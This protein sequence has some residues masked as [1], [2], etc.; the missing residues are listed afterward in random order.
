MLAS[1]DSVLSRTGAANR[2]GQYDSG[3]AT[4]AL[5]VQAAA[6]GLMVHQMGGFDVARVRAFARV[7]ERFMPMAMITVG[8]QLPVDSIPPDARE[9]E[10]APRVR[11]PLTES[12]FEGGWEEAV[13]TT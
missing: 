1:A 5:C 6:L 9:R 13:R 11:R 3:A 8:Y 2:W 7:P 12:F 4:M 10:L